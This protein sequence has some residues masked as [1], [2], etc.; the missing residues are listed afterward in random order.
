MFNFEAYFDDLTDIKIQFLKSNINRLQFN[1]EI[2]WSPEIYVENSIGS[3]KETS[4]YDFEL[5][6]PFN[7]FKTSIDNFTVCITEKRRIEGFFYERLEL[8]DFPIDLQELSIKLTSKKSVKE[9]ILVE[10][11][12]ESSGVNKENF[13]GIIIFE[14]FF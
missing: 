2:Y 7:S 14:F 3:P 11:K 8:N 5:I 1:P 13:A 10:N 6:K 4:T 12:S 9:V